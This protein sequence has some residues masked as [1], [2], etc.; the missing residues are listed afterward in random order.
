MTDLY[1]IADLILQVKVRRV[2]FL[3]GLSFTDLD[4]DS[5]KCHMGA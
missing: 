4:Q 5:E 3:K 1:G 2:E